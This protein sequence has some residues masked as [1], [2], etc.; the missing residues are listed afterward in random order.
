MRLNIYVFVTRIIYKLTWKGCLPAFRIGEERHRRFRN[1]DLDKVPQPGAVKP[2]F[3]EYS[4]LRAHDDP[5]LRDL[6]NN[7]QDAVYDRI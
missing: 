4:A 6:W 7:D 5:V 2:G 3:E 1:E